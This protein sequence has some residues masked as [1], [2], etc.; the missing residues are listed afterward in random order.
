VV[1]RRQLHRFDRI[2]LDPNSDAA[3]LNHSCEL[4]RRDRA[5]QPAFLVAAEEIE[6]G[7]QIVRPPDHAG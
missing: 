4:K 2:G 6:K 7:T 1:V 3:Y 5:E